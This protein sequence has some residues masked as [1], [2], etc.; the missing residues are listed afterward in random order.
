MGKGR[1]TAFLERLALNLREKHRAASAFLIESVQGVAQEAGTSE[2]RVYAS[3]AERR[4]LAGL[5]YSQ[6]PNLSS[7]HLQIALHPDQSKNPV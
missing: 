5:G 1:P 7:A 2:I 6:I 3:A 4:F